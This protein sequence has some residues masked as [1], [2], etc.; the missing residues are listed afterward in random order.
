[1]RLDMFLRNSGLVPRRPQAK[2]ACDMG[3]VR[4]DGHAAKPSSEVRDWV[5][6]RRNAAGT[7]LNSHRKR[8]RF[9][10]VI[11]RTNETRTVKRAY[12]P[13]PFLV[14]SPRPNG[15]L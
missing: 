4:L 8:R 13:A 6:M 7:K 11:N 2:Q 15:S 12:R 1:M 5:I 3:L 14:N 10:W 9:F